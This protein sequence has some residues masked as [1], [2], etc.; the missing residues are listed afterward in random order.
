MAGLKS[1]PFFWIAHSK[2]KGSCIL[3][4]LCMM[5]SLSSNTSQL[6][7]DIFTQGSM[8][9][10][11]GLKNI[12]IHQKQVLEFLQSIFHIHAQRREKLLTYTIIKL[13]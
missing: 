10:Y 9:D 12:D 11:S 8:F 3:E 7:H 5:N 13:F 4:V 2:T 1:R 6:N